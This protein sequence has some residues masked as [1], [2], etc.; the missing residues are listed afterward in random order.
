MPD[1]NKENTINQVWPALSTPCTLHEKLPLLLT[2]DIYV[3]GAMSRYFS[4]F[5][6]KL[7]VS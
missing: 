4:I 1:A 2:F 3:Q 5:F 7:K 6:K